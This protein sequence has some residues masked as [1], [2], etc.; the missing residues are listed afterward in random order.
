[1]RE[2]VR[3]RIPNHMLRLPSFLDIPDAVEQELACGNNSFIRGNQML[4][5]PILHRA[6]TLRGESVV[7]LKV[8]TNAGETFRFHRFAILLITVPSL[9][10]QSII[11]RQIGA[12]LIP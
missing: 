2:A 6:L 12:V 5:G 1:M 10:R 9:A 4:V 7:S 3:F 11:R 8:E